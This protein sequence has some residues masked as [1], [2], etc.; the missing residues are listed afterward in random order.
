MEDK[1]FRALKEF[2]LREYKDDLLTFVGY[3]ETL[4]Q[5]KDK[6]QPLFDDLEKWKFDI[7]YEND[8]SEGYTDG[9][10]EVHLY[11]TDPHNNGDGF[12]DEYASYHYE[13]ELLDDQRMRSYC[14][15]TPEDEGYNPK[16][17]C[18]GEGCD[19]YAPSFRLTKIDTMLHQSF[20][21]DAKDLWKLEEQWDE[22]LIRYKEKQ[23]QLQLEEIEERIRDLEAQKFGLL[24][25]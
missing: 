17:D 14:Q 4:L 18:C 12:Y 3:Y 6:L 19:W 9:K 13:I 8:N 23:K 7:R 21:G 22:Y 5:H 1:F 2:L 11:Q 10:F 24:N 15:C 25:K 20:N 16:Y